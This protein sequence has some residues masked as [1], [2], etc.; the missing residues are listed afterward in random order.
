MRRLAR[1]AI[2]AAA[3]MA[4]TGAA[5]AADPAF[6]PT[7]VSKPLYVSEFVSTWYVRAD[8]G[9]RFYNSPGGSVAG[10]AF[11]DTSFSNAA[12]F[13]LGIGLKANW[14]RADVTASYGLRPQF[15]GSTAV[16]RPDVTA[17]I[18]AITTLFNGYF[19]LGTWHG[20]TPYAGAGIGFSWMRPSDFHSVSLPAV[21]TVSNSGT[22]DIAWA[23]H[24][25]VSYALSQNLLIDSSYRYLNIGSPSGV[26][27]GSGAIEYG[28]MSAHEARIGLRYLI[29]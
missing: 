25:G 12:A 16:A 20:L 1:S 13:D 5:Y 19:D 28:N 21:A 29:D 26:L 14:F 23:L 3:G 24:A 8:V 11:G 15:S 6:P 4:V 9:Y 2:I 17:K 22:F 10:V 18:T 7:L 27:N